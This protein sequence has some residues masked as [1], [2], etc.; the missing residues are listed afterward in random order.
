MHRY[1]SIHTEGGISIDILKTRLC[2]PEFIPSDI[3]G[4][5]CVGAQVNF[6]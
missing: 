3:Q 2:L 5:G 6:V 4:V 1:F